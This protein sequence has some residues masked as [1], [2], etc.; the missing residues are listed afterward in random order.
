M[1]C[2]RRY[3]DETL[4]YFQLPPADWASVQSTNPIERLMKTLRDESRSWG[5]FADAASCERLMYAITIDQNSHHE[6]V[7]RL[8]SAQLS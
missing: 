1:R 7:P 2:C 6:A 3:L 4:T 8:E 5:S